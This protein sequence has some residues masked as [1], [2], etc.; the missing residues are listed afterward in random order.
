MV[1]HQSAFNTNPVA[2]AFRVPSALLVRIRYECHRQ[3]GLLWAT[4]EDT[5][6]EKP[7]DSLPFL[8]FRTF[9]QKDPSR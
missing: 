6:T 9:F 8:G 2:I 4:K 1:G 3:S 5:E 7:H